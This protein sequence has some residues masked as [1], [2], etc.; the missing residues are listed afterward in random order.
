MA[1]SSTDASV[2]AQAVDTGMHGATRQQM[3]QHAIIVNSFISPPGNTEHVTGTQTHH[4]GNILK[5]HNKSEYFRLELP[6]KI[7][8]ILGEK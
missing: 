3:T 4:V 7:V 6:E 5:H 2:A 8:H 1:C